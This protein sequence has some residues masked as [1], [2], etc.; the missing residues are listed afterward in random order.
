MLDRKFLCEECHNNCAFLEV[1]NKNQEKKLLCATCAFKLHDHRIDEQLAKYGFTRE[2]AEDRQKQINKEFDF[3]N[4]FLRENGIEIPDNLLKG[5]MPN[6]TDIK[7]FIKTIE[8]ASKTAMENEQDKKEND[9]NTKQKPKDKQ[10]KIIEQLMSMLGDSTNIFH[11]FPNENSEP[12]IEQ[13]ALQDVTGNE[14]DEEN[15][16]GP[17]SFLVNLVAALG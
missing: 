10:K 17:A 12:Q 16:E 2:N 11:I 1:L 9:N 14:D 13:L 15:N 8:T 6:E 4:K 5:P 7:D 3:A